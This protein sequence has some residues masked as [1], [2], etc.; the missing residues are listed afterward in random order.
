M[1]TDPT[2]L[3]HTSITQEPNRRAASRRAWALTAGTALLV[4]ALGGAAV[5]TRGGD[6]AGDD[7]SAAARRGTPTTIDPT[8]STTSTT[9][10]ALDADAAV[11]V[12]G[13]ATGGGSGGPAAP[14]P[15]P[16]VG[17]LSF[18]TGT[19][20]VGPDDQ[21]GSVTMRNDGGAT[22]HW[23][24][25]A[26]LPEWLD[27]HP[28]VGA[29]APGAA[30]DL[31]MTVDRS[32]LGNGEHAAQVG[33]VADAAFVGQA[34]VA[35]TVAVEKA[36]VTAVA[37]APGVICALQSPGAG[38]KVAAIIAAGPHIA[39]ADMVFAKIDAPNA[40]LQK[41]MAYDEDHDRWV[42]TY[43]STVL[44][45]HALSAYATGADAVHTD[46]GAGAITVIWCA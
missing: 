13:T 5:A 3:D 36:E 6:D 45:V 14:P 30:V 40:D 19:L 38:Q 41:N 34:H 37:G 22:A 44:G 32:S 27:V 33:F 20:G 17:R 42:T 31:V 11:L 43:S 29:L 24:L 12:S 21:Q 1:T 7:A 8:T 18:S 25:A 16:Q 26:G 28:A 35:L 2:H 10:T 4:L 46:G 9:T 23:Q 39:K 15:A